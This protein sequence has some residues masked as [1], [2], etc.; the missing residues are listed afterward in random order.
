MKRFGWKKG[1][2]VQT[3]HLKQ[4]DCEAS[5]L[6]AKDDVTH[7]VWPTDLKHWDCSSEPRLLAL[8][9]RSSLPRRGGIGH[10]FLCHKQGCM[11]TDEMV[12]KSFLLFA[13]RTGTHPKGVRSNRLTLKTKMPYSLSEQWNYQTFLLFCYFSSVTKAFLWQH[14]GAELHGAGWV[15][16]RGWFLSFNL[17]PRGAG[18]RALHGSPSSRTQG[19]CS[20]TPLLM[21]SHC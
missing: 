18:A 4:H 3:P 10:R 2:Y 1:A 15:L 7:Y 5:Q 12:P 21:D 20:V 9:W 8:P 14:T 11:L 13:T 6:K 17:N 19:H 16:S